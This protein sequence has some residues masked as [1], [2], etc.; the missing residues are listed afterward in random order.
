MQRLICN[1]KK[2]QGLKQKNYE[3]AGTKMMFKPC[4]INEVVK[5]SGEIYVKK[6]I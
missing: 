6:L 2:I 5:M 3:L 1:K 4:F